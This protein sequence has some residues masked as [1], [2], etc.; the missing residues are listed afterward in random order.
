MDANAHEVQ[1]ALAKL[2]F[3]AVQDLFFSKSAEFADVVLAASPEPGEGRHVRQHRAAHPAALRG[4]PAARRQPPG[5]AHPHRPRPPPRPRL[6]LRAPVRDHGRGRGHDAALR[7]RHVRAPRRLPEPLLARRGRRHRHAAALHRRLP[8]ARGQGA[9]LPARLD[10][11][12]RGARTPTTTC[13]STRAATWSTSTSATR[14][15]GRPGSTRS[16]RARTSRCPRPLAAERGIATGDWVR[17]VSRR[18]AVRVQALVSDQV[19]T[20][21]CSCRSRRPSTP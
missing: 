20:G 18:G 2:E 3:F 4:L 17:L 8:P 21:S 14:P 13:T 10:A 15:T 5:L 7:R 11:P 16:C 1:A 6:G 9:A 19:R 12:E